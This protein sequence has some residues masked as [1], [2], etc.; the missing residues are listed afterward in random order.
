MRIGVGVITCNRE[1]MFK[2]CIESIPK[3]DELVIV[4]DGEQ[5]K[6]SSYPPFSTEI[7]NA[8]NLGVAASKNIALRTLI[9]K[10]CEH[11]FLLEDDIIIKNPKVF[12]KYIE[13]ASA[14]G[15]WH[16][17]YGLHGSYNRDE[18]GNPKVK[19]SIEYKPGLEAAFYHNILGAFSYYLKGVI[20][21]VGYMDERYRNAFE[22][23][24]HTYR[25]IQKGLHPPFWYF[26][27]IA[28]SQDYIEDQT[29]NYEGSVIRNEKEFAK[30]FQEAMQLFQHKF[31]NIPQRTPETPE[32]Q[33]LKTLEEIQ[34]NYARG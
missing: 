16:L 34:T 30:N 5:Y 26:A 21:N 23:V 22:H 7:R 1:E 10:K 6:N 12:G 25:I 32:D 33:A 2:K 17:N 14:T 28:N 13:T 29:E 4:N 24:D 18:D 11:L 20:K 3:V 8:R 27:D 9:D 19:H 15:I 31:G